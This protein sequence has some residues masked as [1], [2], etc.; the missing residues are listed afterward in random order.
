MVIKVK[1]KLLAHSTD[2]AKLIDTVIELAALGAKR[3]GTTVPKLSPP[4]YSVEMEISVDSDKQLTSTA[5]YKAFKA[6]PL[7][8]YSEQQM[9]DMVWE[10]FRAACY[11]VGVKGRDRTKM[12]EEY[13]EAIKSL[14]E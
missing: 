12:L 10:E 11:S 3:L 9:K 13:L 2:R 5:F 14:S 6:D 8:T 1:Q 7:R 4:L